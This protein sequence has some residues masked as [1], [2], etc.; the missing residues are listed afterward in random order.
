MAT[1][2]EEI[3]T[4]TEETKTEEKKKPKKKYYKLS[5]RT[6]K[7]GKIKKYITIDDSVKP[8]QADKNDV[9][10]YIKCG[11]EIRHKSQQRAEN[12]RKRAKQTGFG[13]KKKAETKT[14]EAKTE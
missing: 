13:N 14:E 5:E 1:N 12:A 8:T 6:L 10:M 7:D 2:T 11:Y 4:K 9:E 3:K